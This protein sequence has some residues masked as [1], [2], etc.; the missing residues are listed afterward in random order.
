MAKTAAK[1]ATESRQQPA[2]TI[3]S[4]CGDVCE[5]PSLVSLPS[6]FSLEGKE[7]RQQPFP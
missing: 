3:Q 2:E 4:M 7:R 1:V 5:Q 6:G